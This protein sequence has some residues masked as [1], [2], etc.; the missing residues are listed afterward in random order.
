MVVER[1][2]QSQKLSTFTQ[3]P[4]W[5][6]CQPDQRC[7][8]PA[9]ARSVQAPENHP[10][11][12]S[13]YFMSTKKKR[14]HPERAQ[15]PSA[16]F[17]TLAHNIEVNDHVHLDAQLPTHIDMSISQEEV[18]TCYALA[19]QYLVRHVDRASFRRVVTR[20]TRRGS[21][22]P[23][24]S[25][26]F[27]DVR[28]RF[29]H[30]RFA[31]SNLD[32][33]HQYPYALHKMT[34]LMGTFQ[35]AFRNSQRLPTLTWGSLL[36][37]ALSP[38]CYR[39]LVRTISDFRPATPASI[40]AHLMAENR[41]LAA[42][43]SSPDTQVTA[44]AFHEMRKI[45]SRQVAFTD[46]LRVIRPSPPLDGVSY[47]LATLNGLMGNMHD[48]LVERRSSGEQDYER[49]VFPLPEEIRQRLL[50]WVSAAH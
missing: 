25:A 40:H 3:R 16:A 29:K 36:G 11:N 21:A 47:Y 35:D 14:F 45:I 1:T 24:E 10:W 19:W 4:S 33:R 42:L 37:I 28:A 12:E 31:R 32:A 50:A 38:L 13:T 15:F 26:A 41:E 46:L 43:V 6:N 22:T 27:K 7:G 8:A 34:S 23:D 18:G 2:V 5:H 9:Y 20:I 30:L 44:R 17:T 48:T 39:M 49:D